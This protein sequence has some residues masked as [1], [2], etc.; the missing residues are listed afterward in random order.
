VNTVILHGCN[1]DLIERLVPDPE[2][3][4]ASSIAKV[5]NLFVKNVSL[6]G[7]RITLRKTVDYLYSPGMRKTDGK[8]HG[9][10]RWLRQQCSGSEY[11]QGYHGTGHTSS[12]DICESPRLG[13]RVT[14]FESFCS[15]KQEVA[16]Y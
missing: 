8:K 10:R 4:H 14:L 5:K 2:S 16:D 3:S 6:Y 15:D 9:E 11:V 12:I 1:S 13:S 7:L